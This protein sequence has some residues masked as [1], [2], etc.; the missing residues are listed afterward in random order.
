MVGESE[1]TSEGCSGQMKLFAQHSWI[2]TLFVLLV[3]LTSFVL[4]DQQRPILSCYTTACNFTVPLV[5]SIWLSLIGGM[6]SMLTGSVFLFLS[7]SVFAYIGSRPVDYTY[8]IAPLAVAVLI[9]TTLELLK[10]TPGVF[11]SSQNPI[12]TLSKRFQFGIK[13]LL[14]WT[15]AMA[16]ILGVGS[17]AVGDRLSFR[18]SSSIATIGLLVIVLSINA[19]TAVWAMMGR[20]VIGKLIISLLI[21]ASLVTFLFQYF[22]LKIWPQLIIVVV[23]YMTLLCL[24]FLLR[25]EGRRFVRFSKVLP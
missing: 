17:L 14:G 13:H 6:R 18:N 24:L 10:L 22:S 9:V 5:F 21:A 16:L 11:C 2:F 25:L 15:T 7:G 8:A 12:G 20:K 4:A 23:P 19:I 3:S 1:S